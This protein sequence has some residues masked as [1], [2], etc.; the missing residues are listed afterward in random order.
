MQTRYSL[1]FES[2]DKKGEMVPIGPQGLTIGRKDGNGLRIADPSVS[3]NHARIEVE[4]GGLKVVDLG[5]TNGTRV[6]TSRVTESKLQ[7][8]DTLYLGNVKFEVVA[9][10][11]FGGS[12]AEPAASKQGDTGE[13]DLEEISLEEL[14]APAPAPARAAERAPEPTRAE[15]VRTEPARHEPRPEARQPQRAEVDI[16]LAGE[17]VSHVSAATLARS[18]KSSK[19]GAIVVVGLLAAG[20]GAWFGLNRDEEGVVARNRPVAPLPGNL[21]PEGWSF[22]GDAESFRVAD[23]AGGAWLRSAS[24]AHSG[25]YGLRADLAQGEWALSRSAA[26]DVK[27]GQQLVAVAQLRASDCAVRLGIEL[28]R[29]DAE[30]TARG[31]A[32]TA[33]MLSSAPDTWTAA[34]V[35]VRVPPGY[36][37]ARVLLLAEAGG[38]GT[39]DADDAGLVV[40]E[41]ARVEHQ[42]GEGRA[43]LDGACALH[44]E[45]VD[46][47]QLSDLRFLAGK[48]ARAPL[49]IEAKLEGA[50]L[51]IGPQGGAKRAALRVGNALLA[52][53]GVATLAA[54]GTQRHA[55]DFARD[56]AEGLLLGG[57]NDLVRLGFAAP[58]RVSGVP[59]GDGLLLEIEWSGTAGVSLQA[60]F[61]AE[62]KLAGDLAHAARNAAKKGDAG[63]AVVKWSELLDRHPYDA[64]LVEEGGR[65]RSQLVEQ[66]LAALRA[67]R[68]RADQARFFRLAQ[69]CEREAAGAREL[70]RRYAGS[71][72]GAE[73]AKLASELESEH[74]ALRAGQGEERKARL[75]GVAAALEASGAQSLAARVKQAADGA[76]APRGN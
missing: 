35:G 33:W 76:Q 37:R 26:V 68:A 73:A 69:M 8:G 31:G 3:G 34:E 38:G 55:G 61:S 65:A 20:V 21:I 67:C 72:V 27:E 46:R 11:A 24:A 15:P 60:D 45:E 44:L 66:G 52:A 29:V 75:L 22:E 59:D 49:G 30:G 71:E 48:D 53:G 32:V 40:R 51:V 70:E 7:P 63:E 12:A 19:L 17:G 62:K 9:T 4:A 18:K 64:A 50:Q 57:G 36:A 43:V 54:S 2:G 25:Q 14:D 74:A 47:V 23:E 56:G 16:S 39:A 41:S 28:V 6:G 13:I 58:A 42:L 10:V 1:R 5:S